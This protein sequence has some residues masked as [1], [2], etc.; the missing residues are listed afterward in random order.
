MKFAQVDK[1]QI[2]VGL[3]TGVCNGLFGAGGGMVAAWA[4]MRFCGFEPAKA[5]A[6]TIGV[7]LPLS[8]VTAIIYM[9]QGSV[10]WRVFLFV[11]PTLLVGSILGAK[12][13]GRLSNLWLNRLFA[14]LMFAAALFLLFG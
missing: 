11:A 8:A 12:L 1:K 6:T 3:C 14:G 13:T 9:V 4:L 7:I 5:H 2:L 10:D